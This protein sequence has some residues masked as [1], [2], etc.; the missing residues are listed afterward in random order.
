VSLPGST[1]YRPARIRRPSR[2]HAA[3][4]RSLVEALQHHIDG[5][6]EHDCKGRRGDRAVED[7]DADRSARCGAP[8]RTLGT[9][10]ARWTR[11]RPPRVHLRPPPAARSRASH[12]CT[13]SWTIR[14][15]VQRVL[16]HVGHCLL[17]LGTFIHPLIF[18]RIRAISD[19]GPNGVSSLNL[20]RRHRI[21]QLTHP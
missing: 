15:P 4:L 21:M 3:A 16:N 7:G 11:P 18:A 20:S 5:G 6:N 10:E 8:K 2:R 19:A 17:Y 13:R 12:R 9:L 1:G 14:Q